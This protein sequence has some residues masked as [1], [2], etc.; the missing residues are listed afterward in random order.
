MY[1]EWKKIAVI[2]RASGWLL[3]REQVRELQEK[4][5]KYRHGLTV[6]AWLL[7][8]TAENHLAG[9]VY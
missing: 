5:R 9:K 3:K 2:I 1:R 6:M 4:F 8:L 7:T